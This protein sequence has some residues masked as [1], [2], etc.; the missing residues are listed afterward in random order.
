MM[1]FNLSLFAVFSLFAVRFNFAAG[2]VP[3]TIFPYQTA[4]F[5]SDPIAAA[6]ID[7]YAEFAASLLY[8]T[9]TPRPPAVLGSQMLKSALPP[10]IEE[11][12]GFRAPGA[13]GAGSLVR[14]RVREAYRALAGP[15]LARIVVGETLTVTAPARAD[16]LAG[17]SA[18]VPCVFEN[19]RST[20][21]QI[22]VFAAEDVPVYA[23]DL[24]AGEAS[25]AWLELPAAVVAERVKL[26]IRANGR[27]AA[28]DFPAL[29]HARGT[30]D[31]AIL[32]EHGVPTPARVYLTGA[33]G[34]ACA[35]A[36]VMHRIVS[37]EF[38]QT[39]SGDAYFFSNGRFAAEL[40]VGDTVVEVVKGLEYRPERRVLRIEP[41]HTGTV[42]L[43]LSR[44]ARLG[45]AGWYGGDAHVHA[46][47][48]A[49]K[50][51][52]PADVLLAAQAEDLSVTNILPCNDPRTATMNDGD[53]FT[54]APATISTAGYIINTG[55]EM[56]NDIFG[57][58]GFLGLKKFVDP[59][60]FGWPHSPYPFDH[61]GNF[62]QVADA[63][64][65]GAAV[66]YV[67]PGLPSEFPVDIALGLAD[68]ID[69]LSQNAEDLPTEYWYRLLNCG[70]RCPVSAGT[71]SFLNIPVHIIPGAGRVYVQVAGPLD[72]A[73]WLAGYRAGRSFA[74]NGPLVKFTAGG[75]GP[76]DEIRADGSVK[77]EVT[78]AAEAFVPMSAIEVV[79]NGRVATRREAGANPH[80]ISLADTVEIKE[81]GWVA[82]RVRGPGHRLAPNDRE[83]YAHTSPVYVTIGGRRPASREDAEFFI[84]QIETLIAKMDNRGTFAH[85]GQRDAIAARFREAKE[86]YRR[87]A[88]AASTR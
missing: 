76:G 20:S 35:P 66:T 30:L 86:I 25:G 27:D 6:A 38:G 9:D 7:R 53:Y 46:N 67:H 22:E 4:T 57:H 15:R 16:F 14:T 73:K 77:L 48:F 50:L 1:R 26:T 28:L 80:A 68:T 61:P 10:F 17:G 58:V 75:R 63:R 33:D 5:V 71:D 12:R 47:L 44:L 55:L 74:T 62:P 34:R 39:G 54:G 3:L 87:V 88:E 65:Q 82:L 60:Y 84:A 23:V 49:Q 40:P 37:G 18:K 19:T 42:T 70:F 59:P 36:G 69:V 2:P 64:A 21:V 43:R 78:A 81:S 45:T 29:V 72:Y 11:W 85:R 24:A 56:R 51:I 13:S 8:W 52:Q 41:G 31:V 83:V 32:D 79:V